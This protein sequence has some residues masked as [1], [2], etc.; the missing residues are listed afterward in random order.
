M[1]TSF[2]QS[3]INAVSALEVAEKKL[4]GQTPSTGTTGTGLKALIEKLKPFADKQEVVKTVLPVLQQRLQELQQAP[5]EF[6]NGIAQDIK[7]TTD[8]NLDG[9][10]ELVKLV[11]NYFRATK[12]LDQTLNELHNPLLQNLQ[13]LNLSNE[14]KT[15][16]QLVDTLV[17]SSSMP[18]GVLNL[19]IAL[20]AVLGSSEGKLSSSPVKFDEGQEIKFLLD[21]SSEVLEILN[22]DP[23][24]VGMTPLSVLQRIAQFTAHL[25]EAKEILK[26]L[27][28]KG[29]SWSGS[30]TDDVQTVLSNW[31][32][33]IQKITELETPGILSDPQQ[34]RLLINQSIKIHDLLEQNFSYLA[35]LARSG[36][37]VSAGTL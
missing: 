36:D 31:E 21:G 15:L 6:I 22:N 27:S 17:L 5:T 2:L 20:R 9:L 12:S 13:S 29:V 18:K 3:L 14:L 34:S 8:D 32:K 30:E 37:L 23:V 16:I 10:Q 11:Q 33:A 7:V 26:T 25:E 24:V 19:R 35:D 28:R 1:A 4:I